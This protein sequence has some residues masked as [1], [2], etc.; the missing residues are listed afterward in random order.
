[1]SKKILM[2]IL[3]V[4]VLIGGIFCVARPG[5]TFLSMV[6]LIGVVMFF[7]AIEDMVTYSERKQLGIANGWNLAGSIISFI[8][9]L[10]IIVSGY[11]EFVT[12]ITLLYFLFT[13]L[14]IAGIINIIIAFKIKKL[15]NTGDPALN[16]V[17]KKWGWQLVLGI[18]V[19]IAG[20]FGFAH[21]FFSMLSIGMIVGIDI[22]VSGINMMV[23]A[24]TI[25]Q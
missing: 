16:Y 8:C 12:G 6:W 22:M 7:H 3:G 15:K 13:W 9:G 11:A 10:A 2:F 23:K 17:G 19:V 25:T 21:P 4:L 20:C 5:L 24:F 18:L 14:I 1:M